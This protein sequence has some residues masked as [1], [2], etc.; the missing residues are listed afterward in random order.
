MENYSAQF[1]EQLAQMQPQGPIVANH[2]TITRSYVTIHGNHNTIRASS[3]TVVGHD[4]RITSN[5]C[6]V[7]G[8]RNI[9]EGSSPEVRGNENQVY[10]N[11]GTISGHGNL[12]NGNSPTV[13][14][15]RNNVTGNYCYVSGNDNVVDGSSASV[16]GHRN[17]VAGRYASA[18]GDFNILTGQHATAYGNHNQVPDPPQNDALQQYLNQIRQSMEQRRQIVVQQAQQAFVRHDAEAALQ[19]NH[20]AMNDPLPEPVPPPPRRLVLQFRRMQVPSIQDLQHDVALEEDDTTSPACI[21]CRENVPICVAL[22]CL[23]MSYCVACARLLSVNQATGD[24]QRVNSVECAKC[25]QPC[26][27]MRRVFVET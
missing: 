7:H 6:T 17:R 11:Y 25:R 23:H 27:D 18:T 1:Q 15:D 16:T 14:G 19:N 26:T 22:P 2:Q 8:H 13:T 9:I 5:Y 24:P 21:I 10:G 3:V 4:N 12:V 20:A